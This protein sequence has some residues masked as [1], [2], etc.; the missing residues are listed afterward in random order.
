MKPILPVLL[1]AMASIS[2]V[3]CNSWGKIA[4]KGTVRNEIV[5]ADIRKN[6]AEDGITGLEINVYENGTATLKGHVKTREDRKKAV[7]DAM[8]VYGVK[9]VDDRIS[10]E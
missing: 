6:L 9:R 7:S 1:L 4:P 3:S 8:K 5:E 2:A 10:I